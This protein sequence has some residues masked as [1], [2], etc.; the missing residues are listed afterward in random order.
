MLSLYLKIL[1]G[2]TRT[3][4]GMQRTFFP[5]ETFLPDLSTNIQCGNSLVDSDFFDDSLLG[6][7]DAGDR[8]INAFDWKE[9]FPDVMRKGGFDAVVGNPPYIR[10]QLLKQSD[11]DQLRYFAGHYRTARQGSYDIYVVFVEK[12]LKLLNK[13]GLLGYILPNKF[14][15]TDYGASL[16]ELLAEGRSLME[17]IDFGRPSVRRCNHVH[18]STFP[19]ICGTGASRICP[20]P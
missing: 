5:S 8:G 4:M 9:A 1:E 13:R 10:I 14:L 7:M 17:L 11:P 16:R 6:Q 3:S 12:G 20:P 19:L 2:E 15:T 18:M